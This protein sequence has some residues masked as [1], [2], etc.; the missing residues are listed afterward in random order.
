MVPH[1]APAYSD[2]GRSSPEEVNELI[3]A[4]LEALHAS[5]ER[6]DAVD[7]GYWRLKPDFLHA[8]GEDDIVVTSTGDP[9]FFDSEGNNYAWMGLG[10]ERFFLIL[11]SVYPCVNPFDA[12]R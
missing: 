4:L 8:R 2:D 6:D 1:D 10:P 7:W 9:A 11:L 12:T 3:G 5:A